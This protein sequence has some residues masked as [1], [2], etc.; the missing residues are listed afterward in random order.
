MHID[1]MDAY[2]QSPK[3][4]TDKMKSWFDSPS[5]WLCSAPSD[6]ITVN[7]ATGNEGEDKDQTWPFH[8]P[9][10]SPLSQH[11]ASLKSQHAQPHQQPQE[12]DSLERVE[13]ARDK[14]EMTRLNGIFSLVLVLSTLFFK[15]LQKSSHIIIPPCYFLLSRNKCLGQRSNCCYSHS[16]SVWRYGTNT[17]IPI[18]RR[19]NIGEPITSASIRTNNNGSLSSLDKVHRFY[20]PT[21][22]KN[23]SDFGSSCCS[24]S[25]IVYHRHYSSQFCTHCDWILYQF[26]HQYR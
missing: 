25:K 7:E 2:F 5:K 14:T 3:D 11:E 23:C 4:A 1:K 21:D 10:P 9:L 15:C 26:F 19:Y 24:Q 17:R 16:Q 6:E 18:Q 13:H 20:T 12:D 8:Q 22:H